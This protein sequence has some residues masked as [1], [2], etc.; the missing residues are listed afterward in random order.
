MA[1]S[2][3]NQDSSTQSQRRRET[4]KERAGVAVSEPGRHGHKRDCCAGEHPRRQRKCPEQRICD[5][6]LRAVWRICD[7]ALRAVWDGCDGRGFYGNRCT[8]PHSC[9]G[10]RTHRQEGRDDKGRSEWEGGKLCQQTRKQCPSAKPEVS[11]TPAITV[12]DLPRRSAAHAVPAPIA[13]PAPIPTTRRPTMS[14]G[15]SCQRRRIKVPSE[16]MSA[17]GRTTTARPT[18]SDSAPPVNR[19]G[20]SPSA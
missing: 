3:L 15:A 8:T 20:R 1:R 4:R 16:A 5:G 9:R 2:G 10:N 6:A 17:P 18:R 11:T 12:P 13:R 19:P 7:G 14:P